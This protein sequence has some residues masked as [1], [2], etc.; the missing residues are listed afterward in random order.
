MSPDLKTSFTKLV[1]KIN[2]K[3]PSSKE[4]LKILLIGMTKEYLHDCKRILWIPSGPGEG[5]RIKT[6]IPNKISSIENWI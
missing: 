4:Q 3:V 2:G 1:S 6:E 5:L